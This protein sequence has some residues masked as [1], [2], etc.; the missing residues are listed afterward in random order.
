MLLVHPI[1]EVIRFLPVLV[2]FV[3]AR[4][5]AGGEQWQLLGIAFPIALGLLR[6]LTTSFRISD[7]R[8][9]LQRGLLNRHVLSTPVDRVRTVDLTSSPIHRVLGLTKVRIGTGTAS[10]SDEDRIDLDGL[11][12]D[13]ARELRE[14]LLRTS[15]ADDDVAAAA[16]PERDVVTF[17]PSWVRFA[18]LTGSGV[19]IAAAALGAGSQLLQAVGF[20]EGLD[21]ESVDR[22]G[23]SLVILVP[24]LVLAALVV[25]SLLSIGGYV[26]SNWGFRLT[27]TRGAAT[28]HLTRGLFT[29]RE[30]TL[31]DDRVAGVSMSEPLGLRLARGA[32]LSA[33]VTGLDR[34]QGSSTLVPPAPRQ[35]VERVAARGPRHSRSGRRA[36]R[37]PRP[38]RGPPALD[39]RSAPGPRRGGRVPR[40]CAPR[41]ALVDPA[42]A[43]R[44]P[45]RRAARLGPHPLAG[46]RTGRGPPGRAVRLRRTP[47]PD[48]RGGPRH[49]LEPAGHLV[50][51]PR[52]P[53]HAG[54]HH[55]RRQP[56]RPR[57]RRARGRGGPGRPCRAPGP[58][59]PVPGLTANVWCRG[60]GCLILRTTLRAGLDTA[61]PAQPVQHRCDLGRG[62][63]T[64]AE[65]LA[66]AEAGRREVLDD[67]RVEV[68]VEV[69]VAVLRRGVAQAAVELDQEAPVLVQHVAPHGSAL[70]PRVQLPAALRQRMR[71]LDPGQVAVLEHGAGAR[72]EVL[73]QSGDPGTPAHP[74]PGRQRRR[75]PGSRRTAAPA[76]VGQDRDGIEVASG[77]LGQVEN[78]VLEPDARWAEVG[79]DALLGVR[80]PVHHDPGRRVE[81]PPPSHHDV[82]RLVVAHGQVTLVERAQGTG[83]AQTGRLRPQHRR[84]RALDPAEWAVVHHIDT[85]V[86]ADQLAAADRPRQLDPSHAEDE[87]LTTGEDARLPVQQCPPVI[88]QS[89]IGAG[90]PWRERVD[91][92]LWTTPGVRR[93]ACEPAPEVPS[94][95]P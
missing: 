92:R 11:P 39:P 3:V 40:R 29:T 81:A 95:T 50:P 24:L 67:G 61:R 34:R 44:P 9:E 74:R 21:L 23:V 18:P 20:F 1:R 76:G 88:H 16:S 2:V 77:G 72:G 53:D 70:D 57:P 64:V 91:V 85:P 31:D 27:R 71:S 62:P 51:A 13:R 4:T 75:E 60:S 73:E 35:V 89:S 38:T 46:P 66:I 84:P 52:R 58:G 94:L 68:P 59:E 83:T 33:I 78:C 10:T 55:R 86:H 32:R 6:Y 17:D 42:R 36:P 56:V 69:P 90:R 82:D 54:R 79:E 14:E 22:P 49:R 26:V 43:A 87:S 37:R 48:P 80:A 25:I 8:I 12:L 41:C 65:D 15:T 30:T 7:G 28:W 5:A 19:V 47:P 63:A 45:R 93:F